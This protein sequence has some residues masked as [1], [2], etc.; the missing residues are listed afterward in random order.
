MKKLS[1]IT[2][3]YNTHDRAQALLDHLAS[4][5]AETF[6]NWE[7]IIVDDCS[8]EEK[9]LIKHS[10]NV[11]HLRVVTDI[12]WNQAGARNLGALLAAGQWGLFFDIDQQIYHTGISY[13]LEH[14]DRLQ[15]DAMYYMMVD[16]FV[17]STINEPLTIHPNT[18]LVNMPTFRSRGMYDEDFAGN[19]G[20]EDLYLPYLWERNGGVRMILGEGSFFNDMK[21]RTPNL[22]RNLEPNKHKSTQKLL[23]GIKRPKNL[24]RFEWKE[25]E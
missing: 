21:F 13:L 3:Y 24:I 17:D 5:P 7:I 6:P 12:P 25:I 11:R 15:H 8:A 1:L 20:Y 14:I 23:E 16:N 22:E 18:F 9:P 10:L 4:Y 2:H 19:Y